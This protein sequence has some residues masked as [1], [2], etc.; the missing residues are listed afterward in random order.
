MPKTEDNQRAG[1]KVSRRRAMAALGGGAVAINAASMGAAAD[2]DNDEAGLQFAIVSDTHLGRNDS[3]TPAR[4]W[5][6][7]VEELAAMPVDFVLH[8][9]DIVDRGREEQYPIYKEI[10]DGLGK[11]IYEIAGNHDPA[12]LFAKH[13]RKTGDMSFVHRGIRFVL[14]GNARSDSHDG[15]ISDGQLEWIEVEC[16]AAA[17]AQQQVIICTHVPIH[18]NRPPDRAWYVKPANGQTGFYE[19]MRR[20]ESRIAAVFQGHFHNGIRGWDDHAP[21]H[22]VI[23][24]SLLYNRDRGLEAKKAPG[25][26]LDEFRP[27]YVV[28]TIS[29]GQLSLRYKPLG[30]EVAAEKRLAL[31]SG[32][33]N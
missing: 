31:P 21:A 30:G 1:M 24:P 32:A 26:N 3:K 10:R 22:E 2:N 5:R 7:A 6:Q 11:P 29:S 4:Q 14:F 8:L 28:A 15:F 12:E 27:G 17:K 13:I 19:I 9:G 18:T 25:Y 16:A 23:C 33:A 20:H